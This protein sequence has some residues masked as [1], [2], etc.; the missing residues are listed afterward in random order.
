M[1]NFNVERIYT[2]KLSINA[3]DVNEFTTDRVEYKSI[4]G[5]MIPMFIVR[6]KSVL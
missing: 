1:K 5:T 4:D 2:T 6:K 3:P